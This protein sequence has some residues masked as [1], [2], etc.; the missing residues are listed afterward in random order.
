M[1]RTS[2]RNR[3][4]GSFQLCDNTE[5]DASNH[6]LY[7]TSIL[8]SPLP[9]PVAR[10]VPPTMRKHC[11]RAFTSKNSTRW[12]FIAL[13]IKEAEMRAGMYRVVRSNISHNDLYA[14]ISITSTRTTLFPYLLSL[15]CIL[16]RW[17]PRIA[18]HRE[19]I[20]CSYR[21]LIS[22]ARY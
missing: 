1:E 17:F 3:A 19:S 15:F 10:L 5:K 12:A 7:A 21:K 18:S 22:S 4:M 11:Q 13:W 9:L 6:Q 14:Y 20:A 8:P 2:T 16:S